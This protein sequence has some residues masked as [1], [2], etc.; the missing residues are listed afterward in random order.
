MLLF[1]PNK[2]LLLQTIIEDVWG[3]QRRTV[4]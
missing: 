3:M 4:A 2:Y 1:E